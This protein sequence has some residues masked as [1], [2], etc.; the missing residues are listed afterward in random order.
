MDSKQ[1]A[2]PVVDVD[3]LLGMVTRAQLEE[4]SGQGR[5]YQ[6]IGELRPPLDPK[7]R[8]TAESFP[9]VHPDHPLDT[10]MRR[11]AQSGLDALPVVSRSNIREL[12]G[13]LSR[14]DTL[15]AYGSQQ[16]AAEPAYKESRTPVAVL[17]GVLIVLAAMAA[18]AGFLSYFYRSE[19][20]ARA[21][22]YYLDGNQLMAKERY[23]EAIEQYR[24]A[25]SISTA[26]EIG[27][28]L[29]RCSRKPGVLMRVRSISGN[30][31][32]TNRQRAGQSRTR[33]D[34]DRARQPARRSEL[35]PQSDLRFM[36]RATS[37]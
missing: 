27:W 16:K 24:D 31:S 8:L 20:S 7:V 21:N 22:Q 3:G 6:T 14:E 1:S 30:Y 26:D 2:W 9:H 33:Q 35:L 23:Q 13:V 11:M 32:V 4:A 37:G 34:R 5:Q 36:V 29:L 18:L 25:L 10:A 28:R 17:G 12:V 15:A 19:R